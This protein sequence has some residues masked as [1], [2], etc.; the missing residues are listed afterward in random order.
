M[1]GALTVVPRE[2]T[3]PSAPSSMSLKAT[4]GS[5]CTGPALQPCKIKLAAEIQTIATKQM[6]KWWKLVR[7]FS[8]HGALLM[9]WTHLPT[10]KEYYHRNRIQL[11]PGK[12][13][14]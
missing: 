14:L 8:P 10:L 3:A 7:A 11:S 2:R 1:A 6:T 9:I 5:L 13:Y 4:K 12:Y